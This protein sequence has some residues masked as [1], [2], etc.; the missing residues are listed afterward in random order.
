MGADEGEPGAR[1]GSRWATPAQADV[2]A[3]GAVIGEGQQPGPPRRSAD[4][5]GADRR[6][7]LLVELA[8]AW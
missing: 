5:R 7:R 2:D 6:P 1:R 3:L 8:V 4:G